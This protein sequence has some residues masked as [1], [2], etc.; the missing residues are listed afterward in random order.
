M[1][2]RRPRKN[3]IHTK[4]K[5]SYGFKEKAIITNNGRKD[6]SLPT[7]AAPHPLTENIVTSSSSQPIQKKG[8]KLMLASEKNKRQRS[9]GAT[10]LRD[11]HI[12]TLVTTS[13]TKQVTDTLVNKAP[14]D[15]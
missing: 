9:D 10:A 4:P 7:K 12:S 11:R 13:A 1:V 2:K 3:S 14:V 5:G 6:K 15:N 8:N